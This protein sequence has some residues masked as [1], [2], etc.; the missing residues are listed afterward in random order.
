M[1]KE[2]VILVVDDFE[3][4]RNLTKAALEKNGY[5]VLTAEHG[6]DALLHCNGIQKIDLIV[7]DYNMPIMDGLAFVKE[8]KKITKYQFTP[9]I[10][11]TTETKE[12]KKQSAFIEGVTGWIKKPYDIQQFLEVVKKAIR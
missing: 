8:V 7:S 10:M 1:E 12:E 5:K 6:K 4:V 3:G 9:I 2:K 11:V